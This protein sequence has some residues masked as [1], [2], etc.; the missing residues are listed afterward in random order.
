MGGDYKNF[1]TKFPHIFI[2]IC[3]DET[4]NLILFFSPLKF[5]NCF[6]DRNNERQERAELKLFMFT[7]ITLS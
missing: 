4:T 3:L 1:V 2:K 6:N 5:I 7:S